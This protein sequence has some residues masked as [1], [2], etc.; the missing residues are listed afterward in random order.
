MRE[1]LEKS[2]AAHKG[3]KGRKRGGTRASE[4][5]GQSSLVE[6]KEGR[7]TQAAELR[8]VG[9]DEYRVPSAAVHG[10]K[11]GRSHTFVGV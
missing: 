9:S 2:K 11:R 5:Y 4:A 10:A 8:Q 7:G 1:K 3:T 6:R